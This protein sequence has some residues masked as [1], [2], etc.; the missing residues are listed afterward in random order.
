MAAGGQHLTLALTGGVDV[1]RVSWVTQRPVSAKCS[2]LYCRFWR[3]P[4][5]VMWTRWFPRTGSLKHVWLSNLKG[6][7]LLWLFWQQKLLIYFSSQVASWVLQ[8]QPAIRSC[9]LWSVRR[10][11]GKAPE[12]RGIPA[13]SLPSLL[14]GTWLGQRTYQG[15]LCECLSL[16]GLGRPSQSS[17]EAVGLTTFHTGLGTA[18]LFWKECPLGGLLVPGQSPLQSCSASKHCFG[19]SF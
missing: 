11:Q 15:L 13:C 12:S 18:L 16:A 8:L 19:T 7:W 5:P 17:S 2:R 9:S 14:V 3:G 1:P 6:V 10:A 4:P